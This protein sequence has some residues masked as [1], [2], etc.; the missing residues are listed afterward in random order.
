M[1]FA[2]HFY[3]IGSAMNRPG[4]DGMWDEEDGFYYDLLRL[5]DGSSQRLK[6]R[7]MVGLLP[8]CATTI[9]EKSMRE[10]IP[11]TMAQVN[12]RLRRIPELKETIHPTGPGHFWRSRARDHGPGQP[13]P[14]APDPDQDARRERVPKPLR[15]PLALQV[16]RAAPVRL[17]RKR[18]RAPGRLPAGRVQHPAC[19]AATP[20][21]GDRSG[22]P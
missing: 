8:L 7:S 9:T 11:Q 16:P 22:C 19:S 3:Y 13:R 14:A 2:E 4:H 17:T 12:E 6:V 21:G 10:R 15:H 1:K 5:P 18:P 20:T